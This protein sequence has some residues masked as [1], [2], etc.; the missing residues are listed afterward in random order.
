MILRSALFLVLILGSGLGQVSHRQLAV[1]LLRNLRHDLADT[2][3]LEKDQVILCLTDESAIG[4]YLAKINPSGRNNHT[5]AANADSVVILVQLLSL[6]INR[7]PDKEGRNL[8]YER[9]LAL[10]VEFALGTRTG[11]WEGSI[12]DYLRMGDLK[13]VLE[14]S[15]PV[16]VQGNYRSSQPG[17]LLVILTTS[18]LL[19]LVGALYFVRS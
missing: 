2:L 14:Q 3:A 7:E 8:S 5:S 18:S 19:A 1:E 9:K 11:Q 15:F 12:R 10:Q 6:E 16:E 4:R 13:S 17:S